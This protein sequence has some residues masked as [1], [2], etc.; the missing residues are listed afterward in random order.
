[1]ERSVALLI[2]VAVVGIVFLGY[3]AYTEF[4][5]ARD[6]Y[7]VA[8]ELIET[9]ESPRDVVNYIHNIVV[10]ALH[11]L[12]GLLGLAAMLTA[13]TITVKVLEEV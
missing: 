2:G 5:K 11:M 13:I 3:V 7:R 4:S 6:Y 12:S 9:A 1:M 10:S 8:E